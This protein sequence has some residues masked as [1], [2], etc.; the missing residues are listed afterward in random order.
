M[1]VL[2]GLFEARV[3]T[4][5]H[6]ALLYFD[7]HR[8]AA[9]KRIQ[10]LKVGGYVAQRPRRAYERSVLFLTKKA[11]QMLTDARRLDGF[12]RL[13]WA[14][15]QK[16]VQVSPQT[17]AHELA[18]MDAK[19]ALVAAVTSAPRLR[20]EQ[21]IT[22]PR[23]CQFNA[24]PAPPS[25]DILVKP[26]GFF[27]ISESGPDPKVPAADHYFF[28]E[29]DRSTE[30]QSRLAI[31]AGCYRDYY[32][33][34]GFARRLGHAATELHRLPFR[35]LMVFNNAERRNNMAENLLLLRPPILSQVWLTTLPELKAIPLGDV[36]IR[37][38]DYRAAIAGTPFASSTALAIVH[39]YR[40]SVGRDALVEDRIVKHPL[41]ASPELLQTSLLREKTGPLRVASDR[42]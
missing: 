19:A 25:P 36:W 40:R 39:P 15:M 5:N 8:E 32:R 23:L 24:R 38:S 16:R 11:F 21:F 42:A 12:P 14:Q 20:I 28:L 22:W 27:W 34:G 41:I 26:D 4:L 3:M 37:P 7:G 1:A 31:R 35:V 6:V 18:V 2:R 13:Q 17:L 29:L 9:K 30:P 33:R 10:K